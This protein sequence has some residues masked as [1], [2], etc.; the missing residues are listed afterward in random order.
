MSIST[1]AR[2][3]VGRQYRMTVLVDFGSSATDYTYGATLKLPPNSMLLSGL[4]NVTSAF[5]GTTPVL[6]VKD[7]AASPV[8]LFG[9]VD[10]TAAAVTDALVA[11]AGHLYTT[12][13]TLTVAVTGSPT[14]GKAVIAL[15]VVQLGRE[16][17]VS[18]S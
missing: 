4:V 17:E 12:G 8:S 1:T 2:S 13:A 9:A 10:A 5:N 3:F 16:N 15:D 18:A 7:N 14:A 6:T 11:N